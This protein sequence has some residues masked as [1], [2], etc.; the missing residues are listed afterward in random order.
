MTTPSPADRI[1]AA[2]QKVRDLASGATPG[3]WLAVPHDRTGHV[4]DRPNALDHLP[5]DE[6][7][8]DDW[9]GATEYVSLA[10]GTTLPAER[11]G[12]LRMSGTYEPQHALIE[13]ELGEV[14]AAQQDEAVASIR[15][16]AALSPAVA[17]PLAAWLDSAAEQA[18]KARIVVVAGLDSPEW[19]Y[20]HVVPAL[21]LADALGVEG[22]T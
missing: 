7:D 22:G 10:M 14:P 2:A 18:D 21:A 17:E 6:S 15:W 11:H 4:D 3:P 8:P 13:Y 20:R 19:A 5:T 12:S 9:D 1:R 16:I